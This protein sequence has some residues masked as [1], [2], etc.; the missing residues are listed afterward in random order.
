MV[1]GR[2]VIIADNDLLNSLT[3]ENMHGDRGER[4]GTWDFGKL[5]AG[6]QGLVPSMRLMVNHPAGPLVAASLMNFK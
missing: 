2:R 5:G 1:R 4:R 6:P 3:L